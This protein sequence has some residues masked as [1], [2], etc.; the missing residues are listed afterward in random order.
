M[1]RRATEN[2]ESHLCMSQHY[3]TFLFLE[4][5]ARDRNKKG[6]ILFL[7]FAEVFEVKLAIASV[8]KVT[9]LSTGFDSVDVFITWEALIGKTANC[10][11]DDSKTWMARLTPFH[12][13]DSVYHTP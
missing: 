2:T 10:L 5:S 7:V 4:H 11:C 1:T 8:S 3:L 12:Q 13:I 6:Y 9:N